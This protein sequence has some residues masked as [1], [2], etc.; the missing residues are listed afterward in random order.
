[1]RGEGWKQVLIYIFIMCCSKVTTKEKSEDRKSR[2]WSPSLSGV[3]F[4]ISIA[5]EIVVIEHP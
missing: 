3:E 1:M 5:K 2:K 4:E